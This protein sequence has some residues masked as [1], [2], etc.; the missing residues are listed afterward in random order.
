VHV[1]LGKANNS[2]ESRKRK[3]SDADQQQELASA[4]SHR[5]LR[6]QLF[7]PIGIFNPGNRCYQIAVL[8]VIAHIFRFF[9]SHHF[10]FRVEIWDSFWV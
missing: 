3:S 2:H 10:S 1:S 9:P 8:Q 5:Q 7:N 6:Q 4:S